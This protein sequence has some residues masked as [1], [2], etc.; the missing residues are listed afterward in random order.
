[1]TIRFRS[2]RL[3]KSQHGSA[4]VELAMVTPLLVLLVLGA[5]DFGRAFYTAMAVT[6]AAHAGA[7]Y[8][9]Q[10]V[11]KAQDS[12][13][14]QAAAVTHAPGMGITA[15]ASRECRCADGTVQACTYTGCGT[16]KVY[17]KITTTKTFATAVNY[18]GIPS[19]LVITR[20]AQI[21]AQ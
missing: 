4:A 18:P 21:R 20:T 17:A 2:P 19:S 9:A 10:S 12:A 7:Q 6:G 16:L 5:Y 15:V 1:M 3:L 14:M 13:G 8:G 11:S